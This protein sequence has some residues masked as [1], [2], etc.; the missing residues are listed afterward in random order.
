MPWPVNPLAAVFALLTGAAGWYYLFYSKAA[1]R[2]EDVEG[3]RLNARRVRL[4]RVG[5][6][7]MFALSV[8]FFAGFN[9]VD[10]HSRPGTFLAVWLSVFVLLAAVIVLGM[11]DVR[12]TQKMRSRLRRQHE[13]RNESSGVPDD[14]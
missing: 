4:R 6:G 10:E 3:Q 13:R 1:Q 2:L 5:G 14:R 12:L 9:A 7:V 8:L 11:I